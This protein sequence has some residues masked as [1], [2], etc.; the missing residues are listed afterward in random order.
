MPNTLEN[1][2][3]NVPINKELKKTDIVIIPVE[4]KTMSV[5][6][7]DIKDNEIGI[8]SLA[9]ICLNGE[10]GIYLTMIR[11]LF[12]L[13]IALDALELITLEK[14]KIKVRL[15]PETSSGK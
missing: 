14:S 11:D 12:S 9:N 15:I 4:I 6:N 8:I 13:L 3:I 10:T 2:I 7:N 5:K 1:A